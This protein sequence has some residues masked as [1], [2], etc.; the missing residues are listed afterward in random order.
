[1][2]WTLG[3]KSSVYPLKLFGLTIPAYAALSTVIL[4][5]AV[6]IVLTLV[7]KLVSQA[8]HADV[9]AREDYA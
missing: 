7:F 8:S 4:N 2:A 1:M 9:T 3:F 5:L 6:A